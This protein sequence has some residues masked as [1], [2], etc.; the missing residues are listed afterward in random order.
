[1]KHKSMHF[2]SM[3]ETTSS[4][5]LS[6]HPN[7]HHST[8]DNY[9]NFLEKKKEPFHFK[10]TEYYLKK[11]SLFKNILNVMPCSVYI[12]NYKTRQYSF[13]SHYCKN[14]LGYTSEE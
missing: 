4:G 7:I 2:Y 3:I 1:M 5:I 12:L 6:T 8:F 11:Y 9:L 13:F 10:D 14:M